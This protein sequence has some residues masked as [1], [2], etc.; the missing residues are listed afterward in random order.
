MCKKCLRGKHV[1]KS[2]LATDFPQRKFI[3]ALCSFL[4]KG[5]LYKTKALAMKCIWLRQY[6]AM[7][8]NVIDIKAFPEPLLMELPRF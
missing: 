7:T 2:D 1:E 3:E 4:S 8:L 5:F 6:R